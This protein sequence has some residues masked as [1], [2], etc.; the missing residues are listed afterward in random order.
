MRELRTL[1]LIGALLTIQSSNAQGR[2]TDFEQGMQA[3]TAGDYAEAFCLRRP[4]ADQGHED[5]R[6]ILL[7]LSGEGV[8]VFARHPEVVYEDGFG[9]QA[10]VKSKSINVR[11]GPGT[12]H[13]VVAHL[14]QDTRVRVVGS[15][16]DW[17]RVILPSGSP[18]ATHK[19]AS[20]HGNLL[21]RL[22]R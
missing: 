22:D 10:R 8:D 3:L 11:G 15:D 19:P 21:K 9:W 4:L 2:P 16:G 20:I 17:Y 7:R 18:V 5:A 14:D 12:G 13:P 6:E 1:A